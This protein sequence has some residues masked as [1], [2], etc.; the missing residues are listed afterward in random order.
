MLGLRPQWPLLA[1]Q[2]LGMMKRFCMRVD[3]KTDSVRKLEA[4]LEVARRWVKAFP[5]WDRVVYV[6]YR[7]FG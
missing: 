4:R 6:D 1:A 5:G 2:D 7:G 3:E